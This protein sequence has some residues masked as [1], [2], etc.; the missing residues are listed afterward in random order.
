LSIE[1]LEER[2]II[3]ISTSNFDSGYFSTSLKFDYLFKLCTGIEMNFSEKFGYKEQQFL[4]MV[5]KMA[6]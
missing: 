1:N 2:R 4:K 3:P 6:D 5:L